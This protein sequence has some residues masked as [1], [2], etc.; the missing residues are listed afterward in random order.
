[1]LSVIGL[2][3]AVVGP[4]SPS[5]AQPS[6]ARVEDWSAVGILTS[7][8]DECWPVW[9]ELIGLMHDVCADRHAG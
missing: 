4:C 6:S 1:M 2:L 7:T 9:R 5:P 3:C 8:W